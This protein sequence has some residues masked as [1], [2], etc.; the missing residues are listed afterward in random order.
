MYFFEKLWNFLQY[1]PTGSSVTTTHICH[2]ERYIRI[3]HVRCHVPY[4]TYNGHAHHKTFL[5]LTCKLQQNSCLSANSVLEN[6]MFRQFCKMVPFQKLSDLLEYQ[7]KKMTCGKFEAG[8]HDH[9]PS[10]A[11]CTASYSTHRYHGVS[12]AVC[13]SIFGINLE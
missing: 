9:L 10:C 7:K 5:H 4:C 2:D 1:F 6:L 13:E 11:G 3:N 8:C 12:G